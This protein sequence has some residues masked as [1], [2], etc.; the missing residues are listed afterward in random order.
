MRPTDINFLADA[1]GGKIT[2][3]AGYIV[4]NVK[5]D[6]RVCEDGDLFVCVVG[7]INNGHDYVRSAYEL[8]C[9]AFLI[10][11]D[12]PIFEDAVYVRV[13]NTEKAFAQM[14]QSYLAQFPVIKI[15]VTGS[16]GK[17]TTKM[18]TAAVM[19][20][21]Y[22]TICSQKNLNTQLGT[23]LTC[24]LADE[25][26]ECIVFE[27]GMDHKGEIS[28]YVEWVR[29]ELAIVT[30]IGISHMERLGSRDAIMDAKM[31]ITERFTEENVLIVNSASDYLG[32]EETIRAHAEN[33]RRFRI[34]PAGIQM[35]TGLESLGTEGIRF[36]INSTE[37]RLPL[38]GEHNAIDACL[39]VA[40]GREYGISDAEAADALSRVEAT[41]RRLKTDKVAGITLLDDSYNASPDS[42]K[43]GIAALASVPA[44][45]RIAVLGD[46]LELG[47]ADVQGHME[48][49]RCAAEK[50]IDIIVATGERKEYYFRGAAEV[51][52]ASVSTIGLE[53]VDS[54]LDMVRQLLRHG[55]A[56]L[57][58]GSNST[59]I[60]RVA[61]M[62]RTMEEV[63]A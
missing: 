5:I 32:D 46:M 61:D 2:G 60:S 41:D 7:E 12:V 4:R 33:K 23:C 21:K 6:S 40:A 15:G 36:Y 37:F 52:D 28:E 22:N 43:A 16:V 3:D 35:C 39:A 47:D 9:R 44:R 54:V 10:S 56:V 48:V 58:K 34:V 17:T 31:E 55:D 24:F 51:A 42:M 30:N 57:V 49:G 38:L 11:E 14:A 59:K 18:L 13:K 8:G 19:S 27:M 1:C 26:T 25:T 50:G 45:R 53:T 62:I 29:P 20:A 63:D